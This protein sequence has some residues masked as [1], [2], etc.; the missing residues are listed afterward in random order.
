MKGQTTNLHRK[1]RATGGHSRFRL[2]A[3]FCV[4]VS[5]LLLSLL[6][7]SQ[8]SE[9]GPVAKSAESPVSRNMAPGV[10]YVGSKV[11]ATCHTEVF[12]NFRQTGMGH[13]MFSADDNSLSGLPSPVTVYDQDLGQYFEIVRKDGHWYQSQYALDSSGQEQFRQTLKMDYVIG[14]GDNGL[15]FLIRRGHYLFEA[16]LSYYSKPHT[17]SFS[18]GYEFRNQA[19]TRPAVAS[20]IGCHSGRPNPVTNQIGLYEDPPFD[21]L[22]VG[23]ENCHGPGDLHVKQRTQEQMMG[24]PPSETADTTIVNPAR[25]SGWL[26]D[27]ICMRCHQAD[28][29]R[30][31]RP[32]TQERDFRPGMQLDR[33]ISIFKIPL[34]PNTAPASMLLQHY[35]GMTVSKCYAASGGALHC[36]SCHDPHVQLSGQ[37]AFDFYR[38]RC[39][40]C[41]NDQSCRLSRE[42][43]VA[44]TPPDDCVGCHMP[45]QTVATITHAALTDHTIPAVPS[46]TK[47][48]SDSTQTH[49]AELLHLTAPLGERG[50]L[51][52]VP[53]LVLMQAYEGLLHSKHE[54][55]EPK[56]DQLLDQLA[57]T[58]PSE[59][60]VVRSLARKAAMKGTSASRQQAIRQVVRL[61]RENSANVDD[62]TL[63]AQLYVLEKRNPEAVAVLE[64][65]RT[66][67]PYFPSIYESLGA[68][69][70]AVGDYRNAIALLKAGLELFPADAKLQSLD[71]DAKSAMLGGPGQ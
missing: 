61:L 57:Q 21:E 69:Y 23:C 10:R 6:A 14:A 32:G 60:A 48:A 18:P 29:V 24:I 34:D 16:P 39:L 47:T 36:T 42:K 20:C 55:F 64:K 66:A 2:P 30:V 63:L 58:Q 54:E 68:Q 70:M 17:W 56:L 19:F 12:N 25:L 15:G 35:F 11:C 62:Y 31:D 27:N 5:L 49:T 3:I 50:D 71:K 1:T 38:A 59:P 44:T 51:K 67:Y 4:A 46:P 28:D 40:K 7:D 33:F 9:K 43:R 13:S 26:S 53:P 65:A 41:H 22:A 52:S 37:A 8:T 45:K